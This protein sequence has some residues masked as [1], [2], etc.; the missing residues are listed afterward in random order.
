MKTTA[1]QCYSPSRERIIAGVGDA[2]C[3]S[4]RLRTKAVQCFLPGSQRIIAAVGDAAVE[5]FA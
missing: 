3:R 4:I 5:A 1:L 2:F